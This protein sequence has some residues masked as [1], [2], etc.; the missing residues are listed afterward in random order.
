MDGDVGYG[1]AE[2][3]L[4]SS[5]QEVLTSAGIKVK[6]RS[7]DPL[8]SLGVLNEPERPLSLSLGFFE[9]MLVYLRP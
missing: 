5:A 6:M 9:S 1:R 2:A 8:H 7:P 3:N 4:G